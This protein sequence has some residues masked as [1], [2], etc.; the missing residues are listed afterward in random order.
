MKMLT[1]QRMA[2]YDQYAINTWGIPSAVLMENAGRGAWRLMKEKGYLAGV[3]R[4]TVVCGRGNNGG[5]GFV[6]G[7]Y[8][9]LDGFTVNVY[10]LCREQELQGD[11]A[12]NMNLFRSLGGDIAEIT[13][14]SENPDRWFHGTHIIIDA[15]F[16][17]GLSRPV[18]GM[19]ATMIEQMNRSG[20]PIIAMD[21]PSGIDGRTGA[22]MGTA[23]YA[24]HTFTFA[25]PK[26]GHLLYPGAYHRG[27]LTVID[28]SI[29]SGLEE[30]LGIDGYIVDGSLIREFLRPRYPWSHKGTYGHTAIVAG[31]TGKTGAAA[32]ASLATLRIGAGLA[33]L[34]IP[35]S[36]NAVMEVK[37]TEV[38]TYPVEDEGTGRFPLSSLDD[39]TR[40]VADKT[41]VAIGPGLSQDQ[42]TMEMVRRLV[43]GIDKPF[44]IDADGIN[45]FQGHLDLFKEV[46]ERAVL[47]P[48][49]GEFARITGISTGE[50][51]ADRLEVGRRF[52]EEHGINLLLKGAPTILFAPDGTVCLNPT[53][54]A[55]LAKGGSGD[56]LT[57]FISGLASQGYPLVQ[58]AMIGAYLH[59]YMADRWVDLNG[60][61]DLLATDLCVGIGQAIK[62]LESGKER[63][64]IEKSL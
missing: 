60:D 12:L 13:D 9:L 36:L 38:M 50:I 17:T 29:P 47:T 51:N 34:A 30:E 35:A 16:G 31:S 46:G 63:I 42:E 59:G 55:A 41:V 57:G 28:I 62:E 61:A 33:T 7:R 19:E 54:N 23:A 25:Y 22:I 44:V 64:Y 3:S 4:V 20:K 53:G 48:H 11:A 15:L 49:P 21:I 56:I 14:S 52:V 39:L 10:L 27:G 18:G 2:Q 6:I 37:T 32:M 43:T 26:P 58:A 1:P 8:A 40:F 24:T 45:A 5:D